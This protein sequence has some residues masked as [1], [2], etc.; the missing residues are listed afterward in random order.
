[1]KLSAAFG[2]LVATI[3]STT[4]AYDAYVPPQV[5]VQSYRQPQQV[6]DHP[7]YCNGPI[8]ERVQL[9]GVFDKD[10][11]FVDMP[12]RKPVKEIVAAFD[13]LPE[14]ATKESI[15]KFVDDN[16]YPIG[17]DIVEAELEDW[18]ENPP[19]LRD[20]TDPVLRGYGMSLHKQWKKL[21]RRQDTSKICKGCESSL[22]PTNNVF[23]VPGGNNSREFRYWNSYYINLG[24]LK[25]GLHKTAKGALQNLLDAVARY[26]FVPTGGRV[27]FTDRSEFPLLPLMIKD[28]FDA[29]HDQAFVSEALPLLQ[30]EYSFWDTYRSGN[31][32][33]TRSGESPSL[34]TR[35]N[36]APGYVTSKTT[37]FGPSLF[38]TAQPSGQSS[39]L[40]SLFLRPENYLQDYVTSKTSM[41]GSNL[42][43]TSL[44]NGDFYAASEAGTT[45]SVQYADLSTAFSG[46]SLFSTSSR[47]RS[48]NIP[49]TNPFADFSKD[50][51]LV[52]GTADINNTIA[53]NLNSILYQSEIIIA[54][55]IKLL[56]NN[57]DTHKSLQYRQSANERRQTMMD[58]TYNPQT[59][60][61]SDYHVSTG[62]QSDI[63][64][65]NSL[66]S[67]WAFADAIPS[68]GSQQALDNLAELHKKFPGGLPNTY[69]NT[70]LLWDW[71]N[72]QS[73][74]Q[75]MAIKSAA[76]IENLSTY[77]KRAG[78]VGKGI[79][80]GIAQSTLTSSFCNWYTTGG[81]ISGVL[82][83][84]DNASGSSSGASFGSYAIGADGN[85]IT[86][87]DASDLGDYAW[88]NS[89]LLWLY[90]EYSRDIEIPTCPNIKLNIVQETTRSLRKLPVRR[91][92]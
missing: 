16:F 64:T 38:S 69:Y 61:F 11:T 87:T 5:T 83:S 15:A 91:Q 10:K 45:P 57:T 24:L 72:V 1:M 85:V 35:Q 9:S 66:W 43:S 19:F 75:H 70:T 88:T 90:D 76:A 78:D 52:L 50:E 28:Y 6:C 63:W 29:T 53:V 20:V 34:A 22:I 67:Y 25:S 30:K 17:Y 37:F 42:F 41:T 79:A 2:C 68:S 8:L 3:A 12:T 48:L 54:D 13:L 56:S 80:A 18:T 86:T 55:F 92:A 32:S 21:A 89:V 31:I 71:P 51:L 82:D 60:L 44:S 26:G 46:P 7:I 58:L 49:S 39:I 36:L 84:Y 73:P 27:Y 62:K 65:I 40:A 59:G 33:Y 14:Y 47:R 74:M 4:T 81:T 23:I 77:G